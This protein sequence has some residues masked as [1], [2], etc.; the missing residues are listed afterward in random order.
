[1]TQWTYADSEN[2]SIY[3][4]ND[5]GGYESRLATDLDID[6]L[7]Y[8]APTPSALEQIAILESSIT[9]RRLREATLT[10]EGKAWLTDIDLQI[11]ELRKGI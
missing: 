8:I 11:S 3:R 7:P 10:K 4:I 6:I 9:I 2:K 5:D 1:M